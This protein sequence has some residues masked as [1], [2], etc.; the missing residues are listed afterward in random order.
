MIRIIP[1]AMLFF[2]SSFSNA[3]TDDTDKIFKALDWIDG[4]SVAAVKS[5]ALE[6]EPL[7][8]IDG[9]VIQRDSQLSASLEGIY[10]NSI[11]DYSVFDEMKAKQH[12]DG[13]KGRNG[14]LLVVLDKKAHRRFTKNIRK[15]EKNSTAKKGEYP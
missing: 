7:I 6:S 8:I 15:L 1:V 13:E 3:Q 4:I 10:E 14:V 12:F 5:G 2:Y 9:I 11:K